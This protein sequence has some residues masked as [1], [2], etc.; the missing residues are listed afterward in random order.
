MS[1]VR[2]QIATR[3][4]LYKEGL[5]N[6]HNFIDAELLEECYKSLNKKAAAGIDEQDWESYE[7]VLPERMGAL[8]S[9]FR[10]GSYK[11]PPVRRVYITKEDG[12]KRPLG[13]PTM[14][15]KLLQTA[16]VQVMEPIY[17]GIFYPFSYGF[18]PGKSQHQA[19]DELSTEV[20]YYKQWYIIDADMQNYFGSIVHAHLR[21][22]I[23]QKVKDGVIKRTIDKWLKAGVL[24]D[25]QL[26]YES[27][28][29]PQGGSISPVLSNIYLH[30]VLDEWYNEMIKPLLKGRNFMLRFADD[31]VMGF[32]HEADARALP[33]IDQA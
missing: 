6:L 11:A 17:E 18:R 32:E 21:E 20:S 31:F 15:D 30:Y 7:Q 23:D 13:I 4:K 9:E 12:S 10:S 28:G 3:S 14:E 24:E 5:T 27:S 25:E 22:F 33:N 26:S 19:L 8:L 2:V 16:V 29:T 1:T